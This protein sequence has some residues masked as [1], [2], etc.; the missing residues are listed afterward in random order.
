[1]SATNVEG[2]A[3]SAFCLM[4]TA[5]LLRRRLRVAAR[6]MRCRFSALLLVEVEREGPPAFATMGVSESMRRS[7]P[8][9]VARKSREENVM[10]VPS[11][12]VSLPAKTDD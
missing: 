7:S 8:V 11:E 2:E 10:R 9:A 1:M 5:G 4:A 6:L 3:P 12:K